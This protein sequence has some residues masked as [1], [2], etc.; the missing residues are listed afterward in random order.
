MDY[1]E[2][3]I[4][5]LNINIIVWTKRLLNTKWALR[6]LLL[7]TRDGMWRLDTCYVDSNA[8]LSDGSLHLSLRW[9]FLHLHVCMLSRFSPV[10]CLVTPWTAALHAPLSMT[11]SRQE[12][13]SGLLCPLSMIFIT[14]G[15]NP[16]IMSPALADRFFTTGITW[17]APSY[18]KS[19]L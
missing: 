14:Q 9:L 17:E 15:L 8:F 4:R 18:T 19:M 6:K 13:W 2:D 10:Q 16:V 3:W 1:H 5:F 11:S 12:Y 7:L